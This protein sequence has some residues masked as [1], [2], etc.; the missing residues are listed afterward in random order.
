MLMSFVEKESKQKERMTKKQMNVRVRGERRSSAPEE[1]LLV[2]S[3]L[4][5]SGMIDD[6]AGKH[7][8][9]AYRLLQ[10]QIC[11]RI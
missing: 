2:R 1:L 9:C 10:I 3:F 4:A 7:V 8:G 11:M 5:S 6:A